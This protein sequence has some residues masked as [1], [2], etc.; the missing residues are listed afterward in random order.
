M[1]NYLLIL[2]LGFLSYLFYLSQDF[3]I[4]VAG[5]AIFMIGMFF[6]EEGFKLFSGG[7]LEMILKRGTDKLY[8]AILS[9]FFST[10]IVQS[11]SLVSVIAISFLSVGLI[12]LSSAIGIIFGANI[13]TTATSW[14]VAY[15]GIKIKISAYAL[16]LIVFGIILR[17][18]KKSSFVGFGN[19]LLGLG[20]I[21]LGI[22]YMKEGFETL[23]N[24]IDL[25][26]FTMSG[27]RGVFIYLVIGMFT[28]VVIQSSS[29]TMAIV[30]TA[31]STYQISYEN[32]LALAIGA[33]IG[34]T[35]TAVIASI[36]SN[37]NGKRLAM[38]HFVFNFVTAFIATIFIYQF[39]NLVEYIATLA[40]V[41][42]DNYVIKLAIFHTIFNV[43]GV[44]VLSPF[45]PQLDRWLKTLFI[46]KEDIVKPEFLDIN[47]ISLPEVSSKMVSKEIEHLYDEVIAFIFKAFTLK[48]NV[49]I[50]T[51]EESLIEHQKDEKFDF[52]REY[53]KRIKYLSAEILSFIL[54]AQNHTTV[55]NREIFDK[56]RLSIEYI[57]SIIKDVKHLK[58]NVNEFLFRHNPLQNEY[59]RVLKNIFR[60]IRDIEYLKIDASNAQNLSKLELIKLDF[61]KSNSFANR[62]I[63]ELIQDKKINNLHIVSLINDNNYYSSIVKHFLI[64]SF[65]LWI[66]DDLKELKLSDEILDM[67]NSTNRYK[68]LNDGKAN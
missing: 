63:N 57:L 8:K 39:V 52:D 35:V 34:T 16:P 12:E 19:I 28:T 7:T 66:D 18:S 45:V 55:E 24:S 29:A 9:G 68:R 50:E 48:P 15:F 60:A 31:L 58:K 51:K 25:A 40:D 42:S 41:A 43:V 23:K 26:Q 61:D 13:G 32:A 37:Q 14:L 67:L 3:T 21:F 2:S 47:S 11:S 38:A 54:N 49:I 27:Y 44:V 56:Y 33:N 64:I 20:F 36:S 22:S 4:V 1:K 10:A 46:T 30:I 59:K 53:E 6:L 65:L 5:V 17:F 62:K